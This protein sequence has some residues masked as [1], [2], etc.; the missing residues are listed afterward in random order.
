VAVWLT[1][2]CWLPPWGSWTQWVAATASH[3]KHHSH[4]ALALLMVRA[5]DQEPWPPL[6][7]MSRQMWPLLQGLQQGRCWSGYMKDTSWWGYIMQGDA[8]YCICTPTYKCVDAGGRE[9]GWRSPLV[10]PAGW[11]RPESW[12]SI[13]F[14][15]RRPPATAFPAAAS[16]AWPWQGCTALT[17]GYRSPNLIRILKACCW[18]KGSSQ[19]SIQGGK[20]GGAQTVAEC[21][22]WM[23]LAWSRPDTCC[24]A[25]LQV[26][27][28]HVRRSPPIRTTSSPLTISCTHL[29]L[30]QAREPWCWGCV[31]PLHENGPHW[32]VRLW[33]QAAL[34]RDETS[35]WGHCAPAELVCSLPMYAAA[36]CTHQQPAGAFPA[37]HSFISLCR[38][39]G[40]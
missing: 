15:W 35:D 40:T 26:R 22:A 5:G 24:D 33:V 9:G 16:L 32:Q 17:S 39:R 36:C 12:S 8:G 7:K 27:A 29:A 14:N 13:A 18:T 37:S 38:E 31:G 11:R 4:P 23:W 3:S 30:I 28:Q 25:R 10:P 1:E 21:G 34:V 19:K 6:Y 20:E 2:G